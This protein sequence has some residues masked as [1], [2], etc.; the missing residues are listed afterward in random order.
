MDTDFTVFTRLRLRNRER[1]CSWQ[2]ITNIRRIVGLEYGRTYTAADVKK[3]LR[4]EH[5]ILL[6]DAD[7]DGFHIKGL[8]LNFFQ[9]QFPSLLLIPGFLQFFVTP[10]VTVETGGKRKKEFYNEREFTEWA[11]H[12]PRE[13]KRARCAPRK[14]KLSW[15]LT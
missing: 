5:V 14:L 12:N 6:T 7:V 15:I 4:Y 2:E 13:A 3:Y 11:A 8:I 1:M 9:C 10:Q